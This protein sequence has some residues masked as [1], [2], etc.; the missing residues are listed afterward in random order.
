MATTLEQ[1]HGATTVSDATHAVHGVP[2][3][4]LSKNERFYQFFQAEVTCTYDSAP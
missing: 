1:N 4:Q 2:P 3:A